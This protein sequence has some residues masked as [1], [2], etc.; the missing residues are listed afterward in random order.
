LFQFLY[1]FLDLHGYLALLYIPNERAHALLNEIILTH[2]VE[3][4]VFGQFTQLSIH[5]WNEYKEEWFVALDA[6]SLV[7][8]TDE[9]KD[10]FPLLK[11]LEV[12]GEHE[13]REGVLELP[14]K[15][16]SRPRVFLFNQVIEDHCLVK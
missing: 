7:A 9:H 3:K 13:G 8:I 11:T 1:S 6:Q 16:I 4:E 5:H 15:V 10:C 12:L 14:K 2:V